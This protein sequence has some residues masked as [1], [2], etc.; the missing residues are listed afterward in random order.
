MALAWWSFGRSGWLALLL[1]VLA[2]ACQQSEDLGSL[3]PGGSCADQV[4]PL[5]EELQ[6]FA[7]QAEAVLCGAAAESCCDSIGL[8]FDDD[9]CR[10][11]AGIEQILRRA[12]F[13]SSEAMDECLQRLEDGVADCSI[14][15]IVLHYFHVCNGLLAG[16]QGFAGECSV[17]LECDSE[18]EGQLLRCDNGHCLPV[19]E[20]ERFRA[21]EGERCA[22]S[23]ELSDQG[24]GTCTRLA[25]TECDAA[26]P[27]TCVDSCHW[28]EGLYCSTEQRCA[29]TVELAEPCTDS[30][31]CGHDAFC[32]EGVCA[33]SASEGEPCEPDATYA[34]VGGTFCGS[35]RVCVPLLQE[36]DAC[37]PEDACA[38]NN[39]ARYFVGCVDGR[40]TREDLPGTAARELCV[41][42]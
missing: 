8:A 31:P 7:R 1:C 25:T 28:D 9:S 20:H 16:T 2:V 35:D 4:E 23:C 33:P 30:G 6:V 41:P 40:C 17:S 39:E 14:D 42:R 24:G 10:V 21:A 36:G 38:P 12:T 18:G 26:R 13:N 15:D 19:I 3:C 27:G 29:P 32:Q 34:C 11:Q 37:E 22:W 5:S